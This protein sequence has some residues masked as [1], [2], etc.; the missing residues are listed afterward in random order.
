MIALR[1]VN[2]IL[3]R[4]KYKNEEMDSSS[5]KRIKRELERLLQ[6]QEFSLKKA[7]LEPPQT[8]KAPKEKK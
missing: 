1:G 4:L 3:L 2:A 5:V 6:Q 8:D 7:R